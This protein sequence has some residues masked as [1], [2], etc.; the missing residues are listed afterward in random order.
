MTESFNKLVDI[1]ARLRGEGGCPWDREQTHKSLK[2]YLAEETYETLD[3]IDSG[4]MEH[5]KEELGDLLLQIVFHSQMAC[6]RGDFSIGDV[7][8]HIS[9]KL[10]RRHPH[11]F[12]ASGADT[13]E[14]VVEQWDEIKKSEKGKTHRRSILDGVPISMPSLMRAMSVQEKA[15]SVGFD[16]EGW[17]GAFAKIEEEVAEL[18]QAMARGEAAEVEKELGDIFFHL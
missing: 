17:E 3:A 12:G 2:P 1:M 5:L 8:A 16:W 11:V 6:E 7:C 14:K 9:E 13:A 10:V 18:R 4:D 15:S